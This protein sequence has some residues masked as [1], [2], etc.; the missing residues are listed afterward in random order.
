MGVE[1]IKIMS[2]YDPFKEF[3]AGIDIEESDIK[4]SFDDIE[5]I[6]GTSLPK[7][8]RLDRTW[9]ANTMR[10]NH[11]KSWLAQ[12]WKVDKVELAQGVVLFTRIIAETTTS[13]RSDKRGNY[14]YFR[15]FLRN[16]TSDQGQLALSFE[17]IE[18]IIQ[19]KLPRIAMS[20]RPWWANT[21]TSPQGASWTSAGWLVENVFL[22]SRI[23]VFRKRGTNPLISIPRYVRNLLENTDHMGRPDNHTLVQ[24]IGFCR[25]IGWYF[26]GT[27]LFERSGLSIE[28]FDDVT[29]VEV[30]EHYEVCKRELKRYH[31]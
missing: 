5:S 10:S 2:K 24:W 20:D 21:K 30:E 22:K 15:S 11:A 29:K 19:K 14:H 1:V 31:I 17:E 9:W 27:A 16:L 8:A 13:P 7:T 6:M 26:E 18:T 23:I 4:I 3:L 28:A 12:G 25:R